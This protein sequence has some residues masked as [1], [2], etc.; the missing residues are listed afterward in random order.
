MIHKKLFGQIGRSVFVILGIS[1]IAAAC[2]TT[3]DNQAL[4]GEATS[5]PSSTPTL[6][7]TNPPTT[8]PTPVPTLAPIEELVLGTIYYVAPYGNDAGDG[9]LDQPWRTLQKAADTAQPGDRIVVRGGI[10]DSP[11]RF[12]R[13]GAE[14][15]EVQEIMLSEGSKVIFFGDVGD[16]QSGDYLYIYHSRYSNNGIYQIT[17]VAAEYVRVADAD[18]IDE[19]SGVEASIGRPVIFTA[20]P[21][22]TVILDP[23][24]LDDAYSTVNLES[25]SY[26][27][28]DGFTVTGSQHAGVA[29]DNASHIVF[30]N[31][32]VYGSQESGF[33]LSN[34]SIYNL[35]IAN[36]IHANGVDTGD[37]SGGSVVIGTL[38]DNAGDDIS[39]HNHV[40]HNHIFDGSG[41]AGVDIR[42]TI[43]YT[44]VEDNLFENNTIDRG[45]ILTGAGCDESL[46]YNN[47]IDGNIGRQDAAGAISI[48][49]SYSDVYNNL[50]VDNTGMAGI[51]LLQQPGNMIFHNTIIGQDVGIGFDD[52]GDILSGT[53]I[54]NNLLSDNGQQIASPGEDWASHGLAIVTNLV[55]GSTEITGDNAIIANPG[56]DE[57]YC[58][59]PGS[60]VIDVGE[61]TAVYIDLYGL[62]RPQ[63][64]A[65]DLGVC[66]R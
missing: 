55:D 43:D 7:P 28:F 60:P 41:G 21:G 10:Y 17:E 61:L 14:L 35:I 16:A 62:M 24:Y 64:I 8:E 1:F 52:G 18:F 59:N 29:F 40:I 9:S 31:S 36:E 2:G 12:T 11:T 44:V 63:G 23:Q 30:R 58:P 39:Y 48:D 22:E 57:S 5:L 32:D 66:E 6:F 3:P 15:A 13:S 42:V 4:T 47:I 37:G 26:L 49:G 54:V 65:P 45:V 50:I 38:E 19:A 25:A 53:C 33:H 51:Y 56:L 46:F 34:G 20:A 27:V